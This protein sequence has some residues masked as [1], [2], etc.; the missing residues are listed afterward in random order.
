VEKTKQGKP[1]RIV[2]VIIPELAQPHWYGYLL[3][4]L[5]GAGLRAL[6]FLGHGDCTIVVTVP[7]YLREDQMPGEVDRK[8][9]G[10]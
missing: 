8:L 1:D 2:A 9:W 7:W 6:L 10:L 4:N 3:D 5:Y